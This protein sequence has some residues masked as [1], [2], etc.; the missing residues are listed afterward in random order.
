MGYLKIEDEQIDA[1]LTERKRLKAKS[2]G[3]K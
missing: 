2:E 3:I 1:I